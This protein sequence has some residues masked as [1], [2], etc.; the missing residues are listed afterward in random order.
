MKETMSP[1]ERLFATLAHQPVDRIPVA[2][3]LHTGTIELM[4][5]CGAFWPEVHSNAELMATLSYEAHRVIGFESV[6]VPFDINIEAE[7]M[8]CEL[9]YHAGRNKGLDIQ[10]PVKEPPVSETGDFSRV[11]DPDPY[12]D[13]RM[14]VVLEAIKLLKK[15]VPDTIPVLSMVVGPFMVAAQVRGVD[16]FMRE[17]MRKPAVTKE[18]IERA[19]KVCVKYAQA[20]VEAG[21]D[22][23]VIV[24]ATASCDLISP[25]QFDEFA[26]P[27]SRSITENISVPTILHICGKNDLL[28]TRMAEVAPG[29]SVDSMVN[30]AYA[31]QTVGE[32]TAMC[33]NIN[34]NGV[35]LFGEP[36]EVKQAVIECIEKGTDVLTTCC[37][38]P[39]QTST[40]NL[41]TMVETGKKHGFRKVWV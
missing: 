7:A 22:V 26:K 27:Y 39:P 9:E 33:G 35:L 20:Q 1:K 28:L 32:N 30:M 21:A 4:K 15:R 29:I 12:K 5:S 18:L 40:I 14:P 37:G 23:V 31:K 8:G 10:P 3:P 13:G 6:R 16:P 38:I 11:K 36:E 25:K 24:D 2:Q 41:Q 19:Q 34:V 17:I